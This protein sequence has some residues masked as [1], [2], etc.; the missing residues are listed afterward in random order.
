MVVLFGRRR[1]RPG[2][3]VPRLRSRGETVSTTKV[4]LHELAPSTDEFL[5]QVAQLQLGFFLTLGLAVEHAPTEADREILAASAALTLTKHRELIAQLRRRHD[6]PEPLLQPYAA[7]R[8]DFQRI[9]RGESWD[10][11]LLGV[12]VTR[13]FLDEFFVEVASGLDGADARELAAI[14]APAPGEDPIAGILHRVIA[15]EPKRSSSLAMWGR[16]LLGDTM[17]VARSALSTESKSLPDDSRVEP[18]YTELIA[19]HT[20][21]M[22]ALGLT[23]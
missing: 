17:L 10:E 8:D 6:D 3:D 19:N 23:A 15:A 14:V 13:G 12:Y 5:G 1:R 21:R 22:D 16:R 7:Q 9:L 2:T 4:D 20:R 11:L 18:V